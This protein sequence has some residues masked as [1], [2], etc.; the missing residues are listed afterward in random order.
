MR[1]HLIVKAT[2]QT[3]WQGQGGLSEI[4]H[5]LTSQMRNCSAERPRGHGTKQLSYSSPEYIAPVDASP[6][7]LALKK[8]NVSRKPLAFS[9]GH[10]AWSRSA[11]TKAS[12]S[13]FRRTLPL[14]D[15]SRRRA[16]EGCLRLDAPGSSMWPY[17]SGNQCTC[18]CAKKSCVSID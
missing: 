6:A 16:D 1:P 14:Q 2:S 18:A 5:R 13:G 9:A 10:S 15:Q 7:A 3:I 17:P 8:S 11:A 4:A 12:R